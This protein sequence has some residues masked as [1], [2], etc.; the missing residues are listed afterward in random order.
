MCVLLGMWSSATVP[1]SAAAAAVVMVVGNP[2]TLQQNQI[3]RQ[4][5]K[6]Q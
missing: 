3:R 2:A 4:Q 1:A 5:G 6:W